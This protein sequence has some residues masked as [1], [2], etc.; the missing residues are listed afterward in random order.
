MSFILRSLLIG[1][2]A[3]AVP[4]GSQSLESTPQSLPGVWAGQASWSD[5]D[6]DG[7]PD[8]AIIGEIVDENGACV[9]IARIYRNDESLLFQDF[10]Q[11]QLVGVY[12]GDVAWG[13]YDNDG[14]RDLAIVGWDVQ[15]E[16]SL[17][18]YANEEGASGPAER[19]LSVDR[20]QIDGVGTST[21]R[22]VRYATVEWGDADNDGD[23]DL[24]VL[25]MEENG[26]SLTRLYMNTS[27][28]LEQDQA[29]SENLVSVHNGAADWG[30]YDND[31]DLDLILSGNNVTTSGGLGSVTEFYKNEPV[32][33]LTLDATV[34]VSTPVKG[35]SVAWGDYDG[36]GNSDLALSGRDNSW[37]AVFQ[38][39]RNRPTGVFNLDE[40]FSLPTTRRVAGRLA[41][42]DYD[43]DGDLDLAASGR[44]HRND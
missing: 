8:L 37:N 11:V 3:Y 41:W 14:D 12:H 27:G 28:L 30:D 19:I 20:T 33:S 31:G 22:G 9:R 13:D 10:A 36:D 1:L 7:D 16:E 6:N 26:T 32:G 40:S 23:L 42:I 25:G 18:L 44:R 5:Y 35:G 24:L 34:S 39:Y 43:N 29:N 2:L 15:D 4:I 38:I 21:L 17:R